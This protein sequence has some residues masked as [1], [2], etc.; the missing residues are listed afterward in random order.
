MAVHFCILVSCSTYPYALL[1]MPILS[2]VLYLVQSYYLRTLRRIQHLELQSS[3]RLHTKFIETANGLEHI[4]AFGWK[5]YSLDG[6]LRL[7]DT[8]QA[9][10]HHRKSLKL[11]FTMFV[12]GISV[13]A[14]T[15]LAASAVLNPQSMSGSSI[16]LALTTIISLKSEVTFLMEFWAELQTSIRSLSR[17]HDF[18]EQTPRES[19]QLASAKE[20]PSL[21]VDWPQN[22]KVAFVDVTSAHG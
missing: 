4:R 2:M 16:G 9:P 15:L 17:I 13:A 11:W 18:I 12:D 20:T 19:E 22:G 8:L 6:A 14:C 5:Q 1:A 7:L 10:L 21:P 3:D